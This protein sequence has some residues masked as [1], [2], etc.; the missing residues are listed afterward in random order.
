[1][2]SKSIS[3]EARQRLRNQEAEELKAVSGH[4]TDHARLDPV[5]S[6]P[7]ERPPGRRWSRLNV[8][9]DFP[10]PPLPLTVTQTARMLGVG[11][12]LVYPL[13]STGEFQWRQLGKRCHRRIPCESV[14]PQ[15]LHRNEHRLDMSDPRP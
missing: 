12:S 3:L 2:S 8:E 7:L 4:T 11:R 6:P 10:M 15:I 5:L 13:M 14:T 1:M 9:E